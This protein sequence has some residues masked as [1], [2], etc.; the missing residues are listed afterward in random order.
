MK[1]QCEYDV[2]WQGRCKNES[3]ENEKYCIEHLNKKCYHCDNQAVGDCH[4]YWGS[5]ICGCPMCE[6]HKDRH[7][8]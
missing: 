6:E 5:F 3:V 2:C 1:N 8:H 4:K 7:H